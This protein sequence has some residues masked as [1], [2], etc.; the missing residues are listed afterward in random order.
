L[1][2]NTAE[3][4]RKM[5]EFSMTGFEIF[6]EGA[7]VRKHLLDWMGLYEGVASIFGCYVNVFE[8][9]LRMENV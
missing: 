3:V 2:E 1:K 9:I 5:L 7:K 4:V 8:L 6:S